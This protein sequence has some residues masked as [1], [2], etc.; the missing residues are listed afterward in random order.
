[1]AGVLLAPGSTGAARS[2]VVCIALSG[3]LLGLIDLAEP[4]IGP[5]LARVLADAALL[6]P[7]LPLL[8]GRWFPG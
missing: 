1:M 7:L 8:G 5:R 6:T 3:A 4:R 2:A